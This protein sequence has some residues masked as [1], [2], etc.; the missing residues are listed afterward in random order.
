MNRK[1]LGL[2]LLVVALALTLTGA[3]LTK[4]YY[5]PHEGTV[6]SLS[7]EEYIDGVKHANGTT[8]SWGS[9]LTAGQ[10]YNK[11][12]RVHN[13]GNVACQIVVHVISLPSDWSLT[14]TGNNT[15]LDAG[16]DVSAK[17]QLTIPS[18]AS[19]TTFSFDVYTIA[20]QV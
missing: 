4:T 11:T 13:T 7:I 14:W 17:M 6:A 18:N 2:G 9:S 8:V 3:I 10:T 19:A 5:H 1:Y 12:Y 15:T 20:T 16:M